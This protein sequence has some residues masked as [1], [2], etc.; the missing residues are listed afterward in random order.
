MF[1]IIWTSLIIITVIHHV[2]NLF[3]MGFCT[4]GLFLALSVFVI[5]IGYFGLKQKIIFGSEYE[6]Q[7][8]SIEGKIKYSGST[9]KEDEAVKYIKQ[10]NQYI[11]LEKPYLNP[12]LTLTQLASDL[13]ISPHHL[14]QIINE[15]FNMNFFEYTN[16]FRVEEVKSRINNPKFESFSLLGIALDSGFNSKSAFN[17]IFKKYTNQTPSQYRSGSTKK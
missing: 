11:Q 5:L 15:H 1:G 14:S 6:Q 8:I 7:A 4:D 17:R 16:Q 13:N 9:L 2:F 12:G 3:S 10:L